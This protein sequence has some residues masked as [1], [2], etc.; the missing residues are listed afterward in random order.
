M[1]T[2]PFSALADFS[3][4]DLRFLQWPVRRGVCAHER[5]GWVLTCFLRVAKKGNYS[6]SS[7]LTSWV[8]CA[9][10]M[11]DETIALCSLTAPRSVELDEPDPVRLENGVLEAFVVN[12]FVCEYV[13]ARACVGV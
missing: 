1:P 12:L 5:R 13:R 8:R 9:R 7:Y 10:K 3:Q 4:S 6:S 2:T 11:R